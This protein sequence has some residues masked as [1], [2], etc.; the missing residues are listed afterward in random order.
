MRKHISDSPSISIDQHVQNKITSLGQSLKQ[1]HAVYLDMC[2]WILLRDAFQKG[3]NSNEN[4]L[5]NLLREKTKSGLV[6]CPISEYTFF[7]LMKQ[8]D[9]TTRSATASLI[10]ELSLGVTLFSEQIL[11]YYEIRHYFYKLLGDSQLLPIEEL[12][13]CKLSYVFG[14]LHPSQTPFDKATELTI[15]KSFFDYMWNISLKKL[16]EQID[17][18]ELNPIDFKELATLLNEGINSH[19]SDIKSYR[20]AYKAEIRGAVEKPSEFFPE[21]LQQCTAD[22]G[23]NSLQFNPSKQKE[24][25]TIFRNAMVIGLEKGKA[26]EQLRT[27]H[28]KASLHAS[29][30]WN[31]GQKL[32]SNDLFDFQHATSALAYCNTFFTEKPLCTM[33][34]QNHLELDKLYECFV[35]A[36]LEEA[37]EI[38]ESLNSTTQ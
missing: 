37:I 28:I 7:E 17:D 35:T 33:I 29:L 26:Q 3:T 13:W 30:R 6:F 36:S 12:V 24:L 34:K 32:D 23:M 9:P 31:K 25:T 18:K 10:D 14:I 1:R 2:F 5:L 4:R 22:N 38:I 15:Q 8:S 16:I 27:I 19:K 11:Q 21:I 20:Q